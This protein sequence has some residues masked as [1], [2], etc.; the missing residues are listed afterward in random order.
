MKRLTLHPNCHIKPYQNKKKYL[1][2]VVT[3]MLAL[4]ALALDVLNLRTE[5]YRNPV[6]IDRSTI[7]LSWQLDSELRGVV[8]TSYA[9]QIATDAAFGNVVWESGTVIS[10]QNIFVELKGFSPKA[11]T[12]YY[13][14]VTVCDNKGGTATSAEKAYFETGLAPAGED[15]PWNGTQWIK[16]STAMQGSEQE[17]PVTDYEVEVKFTV[18]QLAA[19]LIFAASDHSNYY[20]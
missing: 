12:R 5:D 10:D 15:N 1:F 2:S 14:R 13:W 4:P 16:A 6:G 20:M 11:E 9:V 18:K 19:G 8:Q 3:L 7:H 17:G